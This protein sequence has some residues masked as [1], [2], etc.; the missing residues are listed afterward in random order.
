MF[1]PIRVWKKETNVLSL[2]LQSGESTHNLVLGTAFLSHN[3]VIMVLDYWLSAVTPA[4]FTSTIMQKSL[5]QKWRNGMMFL[6]QYL[7]LHSRKMSAH[8]ATPSL[9][10]QKYPTVWQQQDLFSLVGHR[11]NRFSFVY[12]AVKFHHCCD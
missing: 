7:F 6:L 3:L 5:L 10:E 11:E 1:G 12:S 8:W 4:A 2:S 9:S